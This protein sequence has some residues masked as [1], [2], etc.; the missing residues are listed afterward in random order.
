[1]A[2]NRAL[3]WLVS[4]NSHNHDSR[5]IRKDASSGPDTDDAYSIGDATHRFSNIY[6]VAFT[7]TCSSADYADLAEKYT[8]EDPDNCSVGDVVIILIVRYLMS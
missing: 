5:Y 1:M 6:S 3:T 7:G 4:S 2:T 8:F